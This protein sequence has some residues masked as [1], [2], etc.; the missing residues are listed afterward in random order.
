MM[1]RYSLTNRDVALL[2]ALTLRVRC[3]SRAQ[4]ARTWWEDSAAGQ[5]NANARLKVLARAGL[6][7]PFLALAHPEIPL[8]APLY[9]WQPGQANPDFGAAAYRLQVRWQHAAVATPCVLATRA[10]GHR[11]GGHGGRFPRQ[12]EQTHDLHVSALF[13]H[14]REKHPEWVPYWV[15]EERLRE[16]KAAGEKL[17]DALLRLPTGDYIIEWGGIYSKPKLQAFHAHCVEQQ[18]GYEMW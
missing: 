9:V 16:E 11:W 17:P 6:I 1:I 13:L 5:A 3:L 14:Y 10:A 15:S 7:T 2:E 8:H 18:C 12:S 4:I